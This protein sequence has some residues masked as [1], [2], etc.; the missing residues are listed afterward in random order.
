[1]VMILSLDANGSPMSWVTV[2]Q[3]ICYHVKDLVA[4]STGEEQFIM[5]G[6]ISRMTGEQSFV[7]SRSIIAVKG[8]A[9]SGRRFKTP[10]LTNEALFRRDRHLCAYCSTTYHD[11][12]LTRDHIIPRAKNGK[13]SWMNVVTACK[14]CNNLKGD[15][16]PGQLLPKVN[17]VQILGPQLT[18]KME[19]I[20]LPY[21]P[22]QAEHLIM[23]NKKILADQMEFLLQCVPEKSRLKV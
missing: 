21:T 2:E 11:H 22:N 9:K 17:G 13:N 19:P 7:G 16:L 23:N 8:E 20:Y 6:G 14:K 1:M 18:G 10:S 15:T 5:R 12:Q 3:A 4:W